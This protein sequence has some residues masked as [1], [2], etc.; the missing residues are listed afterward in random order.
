MVNIRKITLCDEYSINYI[1]MNI[2][3]NLTLI[4]SK[5][6]FFLKF[7]N[8]DKKSKLC[9]FW[10]KFTIFW[11]DIF[12]LKLVTSFCSNLTKNDKI[13]KFFQKSQ[14]SKQSWNFEG[15]NVKGE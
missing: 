5:F 12:S 3:P 13:Q 9:H 1:M 10:L 7:V 8:F 14:N 15:I 2:Y 11:K 6:Q 4:P